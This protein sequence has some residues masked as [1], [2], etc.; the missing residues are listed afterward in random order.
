MNHTVRRFD[1]RCNHPRLVNLHPALLT[2]S[3]R[4][5]L[6]CGRRIQVNRFERSHFSAHDVVSQNAISSALFSGWSSL[7]NV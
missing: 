6:H 1:I 7:L 4:L 2:N 5:T 3:Q